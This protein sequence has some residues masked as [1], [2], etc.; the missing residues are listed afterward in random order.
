[1]KKGFTIIEMLVV[2]SIIALLSSVLLTSFQEARA[3][4][5]D[6][7]RLREVKEIQNA[8]ELY[9][10]QNGQYPIYSWLRS[11]TPMEWN[12]LQSL[13]N[14]FLSSLPTDPANPPLGATPRATPGNYGYDYFSSNWN[15]LTGGNFYIIVFRLE[16]NIPLGNDRFICGT[17]NTNWDSYDVRN[18]TWG[19]CG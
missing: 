3:K 2:I 1:M 19:M 17:V 11:S 16:K 9:K 12:S 5:R 15:G 14:P 7:E 8:L 18:V 6:A 10:A 13:L 4:A